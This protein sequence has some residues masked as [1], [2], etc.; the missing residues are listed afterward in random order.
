MKR[1]LILLSVFTTLSSYANINSYLFEVEQG[2]YTPITG[3]TVLWSGT[4]DDSEAWVEIP[5][6]NYNGKSHDSIYVTTNGWVSFGHEPNWYHRNFIP[7]GI[8]TDEA[9]FLSPFA[10][11]LANASSGNPE[12]SYKQI[13]DLLIIQY[14]DVARYGVSGE[15]IS[16]QIQLNTK[17]YSISFVY[18]GTI[19][20]GNDNLNPQVGIRGANNSDFIA[21][22]I[23]ETGS[24]SNPT[25]S[26]VN[27]SRCYFNSSH[28]SVVPASG[29]TY[30]FYYNVLNSICKETP[31][32]MYDVSH[33]GQPNRIMCMKEEGNFLW[34]G[35]TGGIIK[36]NISTGVVVAR[37]DV[38]NVLDDNV[39]YDIEID[40]F[41]NKWF[42]NLSALVKFDNTNWTKYTRHNTNF[43][44]QHSITTI[45]IDQ[46]NK[47]WIGSESSPNIVS[48]D[49]NSWKVYDALGMN[50]SAS[51]IYANDLQIDDYNN[52]W[53]G[54]TTEGVFK[55]DGSKWYNYNTSN[56]GI[57]ADYIKSVTVGNSDTMYFCTGNGAANFRGCNVFA[58]NKWKTLY[59][60]NDSANYWWVWFPKMSIDSKGKKWFTSYGS[61]MYVFDGN[62]WNRYDS[63]STPLLDNLLDVVYCDAYGN[64]WCGSRKGISKYTNGKW[65]NYTL[66]TELIGNNI[67]R[68]RRD[69]NN[70]LWI[71]TRDG[72]SVYNDTIWKAYQNPGYYFFDFD[73]DS[74]GDLWIVQYRGGI[75][76][77]NP[78]TE[79]FTY[80]GTLSNVLNPRD[81]KIDINDDLWI[82]TIY[83]GLFYIKN[84]LSVVNNYLPSNSQIPS[85]IVNSIE[86]DKNNVVWLGTNNGLVK[87]DNSNWTIFNSS[88]SGLTDNYINSVLMD[89][90]NKIW[91]GL[92]NNG[93]CNFD[94][95]NWT[96]FN[97]L[98]EGYNSISI[99]DVFEDADNNI[100]IASN[101]D[102]GVSKYDG[103]KWTTYNKTNGLIDANVNVIGQ[104]RNG[105]IWLGTITGATRLECKNPIPDFDFNTTCYPSSTQIYSTSCNTD[106]SSKLEWDLDNNGTYD[107][108][109]FSFIHTFSNSGSFPVKLRITN[110]NCV[111]DI[112][113][114]VVVGLKPQISLSQNGSISLC[115]GTSAT[116][117]ANISNYN[118]IFNYEYNWST[119]DTSNQIIVNESGFYKVEVGI[120]ECKSD[121]D[122]VSVNVLTP[123]D[124]AEI[125]M[126]T[127]DPA[128]GKN[129]II[130]E[131]YQNRRIASYNIYKLFGSTYLPIGNVAFNQLS[132][133]LDYTSDPNTRAARY[134]ISVI[135]TCGN[136]SA[137]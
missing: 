56:S 78:K 29:L 42:A 127:V 7:L 111:S 44:L 3:G 61:G 12:I 26:P 45:T 9:G 96:N 130:W 8:S 134:A 132:V 31:N 32:T 58:N 21:L 28:S 99:F 40:A 66:K 38:S 137:N 93:I 23:L 123:F 53:V 105:Y 95:T 65:I 124:S 82:G 135:D 94:G 126:V 97:Y 87:I 35:T 88:N 122:S 15:I 102:M 37:Y 30:K 108:E 43:T 92:N 83:N 98:T 46:N 75:R 55:F 49:G 16:F 17:D 57:T 112:T 117:T 109:G 20:A 47:L 80:I 104:D 125:C 36:R 84:D 100:W 114:N 11:D 41:G 64:V 113:K 89:S 76:K 62:N 79:T 73:F 74:K 50:S 39:V 131:R 106:P 25:F 81:I 51:Y 119:G 136:E 70:N 101:Y 118:S 5:A 48:Y 52:L 69:Q 115:D 71:M 77:F 13:G 60:Y 63:S 67:Q 19:T 72:L 91:L 4:F 90:K 86:I 18:G 133:F 34:I 2:T 128:T 107:K 103:T 68:I 22:N 10:A 54:T 33:Y 110:D 1:I 121:I 85:D 129:L 27:N 120:D 24:W 59:A 6:F 116:L 14:Q